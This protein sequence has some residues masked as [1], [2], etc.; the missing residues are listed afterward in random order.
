MRP[1]PRA[2]SGSE[3]IGRARPGPHLSV[4]DDT[5]RVLEQALQSPNAMRQAI[6]APMAYTVMTS[7]GDPLPAGVMAGVTHGIYSELERRGIAVEPPLRGVPRW[8]DLPLRA[9]ALAGWGLAGGV[10][11][12]RLRHPR[13]LLDDTS[14]THL[15][16]LGASLLAGRRVRRDQ[17]ISTVITW[18]SGLHHLPPGVQ[19]ITYD[20]ATVLQLSRY[21]PWWW[22][23]LPPSEIRRLANHSRSGYERASVCC[24]A[25]SW[26]KASMVTEL[27][28]PEEKVVVVGVGRN[29]SPRFIAD[30]DWHSPHFLYIGVD[31]ERKN[32]AMLLGAFRRVRERRPNI[33]LSI[34]GHAPRIDEPGV[35]FHGVIPLGAPGTEERLAELFAQ[36]TCFVLPSVVEPAG[37]ATLEAM[38]A[39]MPA[40]G[41]TVGGSGELIGDGGTVVDPY[42]EEALVVAMDRFADADAARRTGAIA[43]ERATPF[44]WASV[45]QRILDA[46]GAAPTALA[47]D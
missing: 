9:V 34:V 23:G 19:L 26:A 4:A 16:L 24:V 11:P 44:T 22:S 38:S 13:M 10:T 45:T 30:R 3:A 27:G 7:R 31:W 29:H 47:S 37:V 32:G 14:H 42:D 40:I 46:A 18:G 41:T 6:L 25:T 17:R 2:L 5:E 1:P 28:V 35:T 15:P 8:I 33:R 21:A 36:A 20:D 12:G 39:G 43:A